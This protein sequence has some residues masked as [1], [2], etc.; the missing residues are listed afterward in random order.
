QAAIAECRLEVSAIVL[1]G[2][3]QPE[4]DGAGLAELAAAADVDLHVDPAGHFRQ[5]QRRADIHALD[6]EREILVDIQP[7]YLKL[8]GAISNTDPGDRRLPAP[9]SPRVLNLR[10][11]GHELPFFL[12][13]LSN[14][15]QP[16]SA[17]G[18]LSSRDPV[19]P[20]R[21]PV[22]QTARMTSSR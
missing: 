14:V 19:I 18:I 4:H 2:A 22:R 13:H 8:P 1:Q 16:P 12:K 17:V 7:V 21:A 6:F 20:D 5:S 3:G 10:R 11:R 15:G 9:R